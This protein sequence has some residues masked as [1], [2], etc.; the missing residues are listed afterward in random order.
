MQ[1][2]PEQSIEFVKNSIS[3]GYE[4]PYEAIGVRKNGSEFPMRLEA[5]NVPYKGKMVRTVE[6]RD[7]TEQ[8]NAEL[9]IKGYV[10]FWKDVEVS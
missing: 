3:T 8:K 6:F 2:I 10:G 1:L 9:E 7:I 4:K 5:R